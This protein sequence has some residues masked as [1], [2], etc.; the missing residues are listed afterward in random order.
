MKSLEEMLMARPPRYPD[1]G[2]D[3]DVGPGPEST[4]ERSHWVYVFWIVGI[5]L[6]LLL[7]VLHLTG[8]I[9]LGHH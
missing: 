8:T 6:I 5:A 7:V 3:T 2:D 9:G 1:T 4:T